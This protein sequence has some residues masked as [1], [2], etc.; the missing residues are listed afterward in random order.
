MD[1]ITGLT[2]S[3]GHNDIMVVVDC[4]TKYA[5]FIALS[6]P[7]TT[8]KVENVFLENIEKLYGHLRLLLVIMILSLLVTFGKIYSH[9]GYLISS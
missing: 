7:F 6:H 3:K 8:S 5:H 9:V 2:K 1:F 4:L